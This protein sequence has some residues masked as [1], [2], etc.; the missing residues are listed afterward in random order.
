MS[1]MPSLGAMPSVAAPAAVVQPVVVHAIAAPAPAPANNIQIHAQ[2]IMNHP[3]RLTYTTS[4][5]HTY[6][7]LYQLPPEDQRE[8]E[9]IYRA[10]NPEGH[11]DFQ[12]NVSQQY[13][14]LGADGA[15]R[16]CGENDQ[17]LQDLRVLVQKIYGDKHIS[18]KK[19]PAGWRSSASEQPSFSPTTERLKMLTFGDQHVEKTLKGK[20]PAVKIAYLQRDRAA[21]HV[22]VK[23][24]EVLQ[25]VHRD[26]PVGQLDT[27]RRQAM[28]V[29]TGRHLEEPTFQATLAFEAAHKLTPAAT[30]AELQAKK[31]QAKEWIEGHRTGLTKSACDKVGFVKS[32]CDKTGL[33]VGESSGIVGEA[34]TQYAE[35]LARLGCPD[36]Q[37][38]A[39]LGADERAEGPE[40]FY[41]RLAD[42]V[43]TNNVVEI[44]AVMNS[45]L[46][47]LAFGQLDVHDQEQV[48]RNL[49][50]SVSQL[51]VR[52][53]PTDRQLDEFRHVAR[54]DEDPRAQMMLLPGDFDRILLSPNH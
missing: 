5:G 3:V 25:A 21:R 27:G 11:P 43:A 29:Q 33:G 47:D 23:T 31:T 51:G 4:S 20:A 17:N 54:E 22:L 1:S 7:L 37:T 39:L 52:L 9:R 6:P 42:A 40:L 35:D 49:T 44:N 41:S 2:V 36:R 8:L 38:Y 12:F 16:E 18:W 10:L 46:F 32:F 53:Q 19:Y 15:V 28:L 24:R 30:A 34:E 45:P 48:R 14:R 13:S 26:V 50:V